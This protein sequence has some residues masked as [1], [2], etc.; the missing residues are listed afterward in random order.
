VKACTEVGSAGT[1]GHLHDADTGDPCFKSS[2]PHSR[3]GWVCC[4]GSFPQPLGNPIT[5]VTDSSGFAKIKYLPPQS[6][7]VGKPYYISGQDRIVATLL[8]DPSVKREEPLRTRVPGLEP[9]FGSANCLG[10]PVIAFPTFGQQ[11][12]DCFYWGY[13]SYQCAAVNHRERIRAKTD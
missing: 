10:G 2:S 9:M 4:G 5:V 1:D 6:T 7:V 13:A 3:L 12:Y 8:S 11:N